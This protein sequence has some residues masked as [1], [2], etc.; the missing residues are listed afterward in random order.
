MCVSVLY[1]CDFKR[2]FVYEYASV[3]DV[4]LHA[5][6]AYSQTQYTG[7]RNKVCRLM[8]IAKYINTRHQL[9]I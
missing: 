6:Y 5:G 4:G 2:V 9:Y 7:K 3:H 1:L 8:Q